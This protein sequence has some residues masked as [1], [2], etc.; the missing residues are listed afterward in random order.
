MRFIGFFTA[1][2]RNP[3]TRRVYGRA[4]AVGD[5]CGW[6]D[7]LGRGLVELQPVHVAAYVEQLGR[8]RAAPT[9]KQHLAVIRMLFEWLV[10]GQVLQTNPA[11]SVRGPRHVVETG[12]T[13]VLSAEEVR[14]VLDAIDVEDG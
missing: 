14:A 5:F 13:P 4:V 1:N 9:V 7:G 3:N 11:A 10:I 8:D 6:C 2:I 12:K